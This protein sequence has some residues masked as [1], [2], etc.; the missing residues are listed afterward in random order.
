MLRN[1]W[2]Y[3]DD[4]YYILQNPHVRPGLTPDGVVW[5]L[6]GTLGG[7]WHPLTALA[8]MTNVS[9][10]GLHPAGHHAVS[11]ILH[12]LNAAL[13]AWALLE[14]S[15]AWWPSV[16]VA[17]LFALH[18][19]RVESVAWAAE[20][21]TCS[22]ARSSCSRCSPIGAGW[23]DRARRVTPRCCSASRSRSWPSRWW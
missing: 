3:T 18:P 17:A 15:G 7:N 13:V 4:P 6:S 21:R 5:A 11:L 20:L 22:R 9:L 16:A 19:L 1:D 23:R 2:T 12:A 10:F 8:H 14:Y